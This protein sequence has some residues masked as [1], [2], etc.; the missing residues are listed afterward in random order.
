MDTMSMKMKTMVLEALLERARKYQNATR[1]TEVDDIVKEMEDIMD[2]WESLAP[3]MTDQEEAS[4]YW[5][6]VREQMTNLTSEAQNVYQTNPS[7]SYS[8]FGW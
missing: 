7:S 6:E 3:D 8:R 1:A 5:K 4:D 2:E